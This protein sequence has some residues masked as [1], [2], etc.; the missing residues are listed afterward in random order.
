LRGGGGG[1]E[2]KGRR[3]DRS[4]EWLCTVDEPDLSVLCTSAWECGEGEAKGRGV[5]YY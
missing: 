4:A 2:A 5:I 3:V 1:R